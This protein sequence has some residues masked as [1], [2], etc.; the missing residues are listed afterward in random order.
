MSSTIAIGGPVVLMESTVPTADS[1][2]NSYAADVIGNKTDTVAGDSLVGICKLILASIGGGVDID[3]L[4]ANVGDASGDSLISIVAKLGDDTL[5]VKARFDAVVALSAVPAEDAATDT[6]MRD[7]VG[8]KSDTIA[9]TSLVALAKQIKAA[10]DAVQAVT[11]LLPEAGA[12]TSL[13]L[14]A[15]V[16]TAL[17]SLG[18]PSGDTLTSITAK[19]GDDALT[20]KARLDAL[21][22]AVGLTM[23]A[24]ELAVST[25]DSVDNVDIVDVIGN[26]S[27]TVAGTSVIGLLKAIKAKTDTIA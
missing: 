21:D 1:A 22:T 11:D 4:L 7:V 16:S 3:A 5:T 8:K 20:L 25:A 14:D 15:D 23:L 26:K 13:A 27:D 2:D 17:T 12:L 6:N 18:D 24:T 9:G 10:A 19:L